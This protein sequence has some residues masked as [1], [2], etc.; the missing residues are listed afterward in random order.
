MEN[1]WLISATGP[2]YEVFYNLAF[3][4][5][6]ALLVFEG[7]KRKFPMLKWIFL[8]LFSRILFIVGTKIVTIPLNEWTQLFTQLR[9]PAAPGKSLLGGILFGFAA[10]I[11]GSYFLKFRENIADAFAFALPVAIAIQRAGC[12]MAGCCFG[13]PNALPWAVQYPVNTLPHFHQF[14][15]QLISFPEIISL[16]V[17]PVQLYEMAGLLIGLFFLFHFRRKPGKP[18][19]CFCF[20]SCSFLAF[21]FFQNFSGMPMPTPLAEKWWA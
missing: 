13:K 8:F 17:H 16:P 6:L 12:F 18:G 14:T 1:Y 19:V 10:L 4:V 2:W 3:L 15:D 7:W 20:R 5:A 21:F 11:A 9:L